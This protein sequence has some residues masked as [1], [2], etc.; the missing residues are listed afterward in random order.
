M[1]V[2]IG[3]SSGVHYPPMGTQ[4]TYYF[5]VATLSW[6]DPV[7]GL[8]EV[9]KAGEPPST[10][11]L[12]QITKAH[13]CRF[14]NLLTCSIVVKD[15]KIVSRAADSE[16]GLY[17][18]PSYQGTPPQ[19][20]KIRRDVDTWDEKHAVF[21]QTVGCRTMAPELIGSFM[22]G[23]IGGTI[24][25]GGQ[26]GFNTWGVDIGANIG[27]E[28]AELATAFPPIW[29]TL[30][31]TMLA[32]GVATGQLVAHSLFPSLS[33]YESVGG[34]RASSTKPLMWVRTNKSY[35]AVTQLDMWKK[36]GWG[37]GNPWSVLDPGKVRN[38]RI[39]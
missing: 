18:R 37:R 26:P 15:G 10:L 6:I 20:Y 5:S 28:V 8:P 34:G 25:N 39:R 13:I 38:D 11:S 1:E 4:K 21:V 22:G 2:D 14:S 23:F 12:H 3:A 32:T 16:C 27:R 33:C 29:T 24:L 19:S 7:T 17:M 9:D 30:R 36:T 35:N 31:V